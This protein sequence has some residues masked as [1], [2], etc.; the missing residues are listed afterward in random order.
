MRTGGRALLLLALSTFGLDAQG[1]SED[2]IA[3]A[4][5]QGA[6][7]RSVDKVSGDVTDL[8]LVSGDRV[9]IGSLSVRLAECR[10]PPENIQGEAYAW[11][12]IRDG[13]DLLFSGWMVAS[14]PALNALDHPRYDVWVLR[15]RSS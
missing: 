1:L 12:D 4:T 13:D 6:V 10:Y 5:G 9:G 8:A 3:T 11:L 15:C 7:L 2:V 14:S